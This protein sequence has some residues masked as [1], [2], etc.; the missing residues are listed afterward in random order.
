[1]KNI[2]LTFCILFAVQLAYS[3]DTI[4][5]KAFDYNSQTRDTFVTF[6]E[7]TDSYR[8]IL[9]LYNMRC[10][11]ARVSTGSNRN[12]GCGEWDYSCNTYVE[13]NSRTDSLSASTADYFISGFSGNEYNYSNSPTNT[14]YRNIQKKATLNMVTDSSSGS[15]GAGNNEVTY[16]IPISNN[17]ESGYAGKSQFIYSAE[18]LIAAGVS[19]GEIDA[20]SLNAKNVA[21]VANL[22]INILA[23]S[24]DSFQLSDLDLQGFT[25]VFSDD[26]S[27]NASN[28]L[29]T[30]HTP[31]VWDGSSNLIFEFSANSK[32]ISLLEIESHAIDSTV[33]I[34]A[35]SGHSLYFDGA[36]N[37][38]EANSFKGILGTNNRTIEAWI[39]T[40][41]VNGEI[42]SWGND[43]SG[44]KWVFRVN[45]DGTLRTEVNGG[46][47]NGTTNIADNQW[48]HVACVFAG[49]DVSDI[50]HYVDGVLETNGA[51][52][53][54]SINTTA[55][56]NVRVSRGINNRYFRGDIDGLH[57]WDEALTATRVAD[58]KNRLINP[59]DER[60]VLNYKFDVVNSD[61]VLCS[62][63]NSKPGTIMGNPTY[64]SFRAQQIFKDF[65]ISPYRP[66][67]RVHQGNFDFTISEVFDFDLV[68]NHPNSVTRYTIKSNVGTNIDDEKVIAETYNKWDA[69]KKE[70]FYDENNLLYD[71]A[72]VTSDGTITV[73]QLNYIRR[74]PSRLEIMSF[75]TPYGIG[76][77]LGAEGKTWTFDMT[78]FTPILKGEKR[79][80]LSRGG[81]NQEEMDIEFLFIKGTPAREV[82]DI[83]QIWPTQQYQPNFSQILADDVYFP[84]VAFNTLDSAKSFK[85]RSAITGHGQQGEFM[86][87]THFIKA[88]DQNFERSV[89][90]ACGKNPVYPQG[91]TWI[92]DRAGWCPG[93]ATD[94]AE[95]EISDVSGGDVITLDYGIANGEGDSRY[96]VNNQIVSYGEYNHGYDLGI[97]D[98]MEPS[99]KVEHALNNP[100]C[101]N[102]KMK[103]V[104]NGVNTVNSITVEYWV[105]DP[106][107][108][109]SFTWPCYLSTNG[110]EEIHFPIDNG[111]WSS[112]VPGDSKFYAK[113]VAID[114]NPGADEDASNNTYVSEF[115]FPEVYP[116]NFYLFYRTNNA[117][118]ETSVKIEDEWGTVVFQRDNHANATIYR[119]T[120]NLGL[121][122]Y[123][124]TID[125]SDN[126]GISFWANNDGSGF[127]RLWEVGG[128]IFK[129]IQPD[130]GS[131]SIVNFTVVHT[132]DV[133]EHEVDLG[134]HL[135]PNPST[136]LITVDGGDM[137]G[138]VPTLYNSMGQ[139][140]NAP[141][142]RTESTL[143]YDLENFPSGIY[144]LSIVKNGYTWTQKV[145]KH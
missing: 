33:G 95:Y 31:F 126:D 23:T 89:W 14:H 118:D 73:G 60:I 67:I 17:P 71:S 24:K 50:K 39:K 91:G 6:P 139:E 115:E 36:S 124:L 40:D 110:V 64:N 121:G 59:Q 145:V 116:S 113:I 85:I 120:L 92:Y 79:I 43:A 26:I 81:Q 114:G 11:G 84:P 35:F 21:Q 42:C 129:T 20:I 16:M 137:Q 101:I 108:K 132:L 144:Y 78:D 102:P 56:I 62:A 45:G 87:R 143:T 136:G 66:N 90:K 128:S 122:C 97:I 27:F 93:M 96:I 112:A 8:Q 135:Y 103:V 107:N 53:N 54:R 109:R 94:L 100:M 61:I 25:N 130:F 18:E 48:H 140:I 51:L 104:N 41:K 125:D 1:M 3:Q 57:I 22:Q 30:F 55:G 98:I 134:Y 2:A 37:Y 127:F 72:S 74:W 58:V 47:L 141:S 111:I 70:Y 133:P 12:L 82:L 32:P 28:K 52:T 5:L 15:V 13:D 65:Y 131:Q 29:I 68:P 49:T 4:R 34:V 19:A 88:N 80:F 142:Q 119:D 77:D 99:N 9:M 46:G 105:N 75:V 76:L 63:I 106:N 38:V 44:E 86:P 7:G 117:A 10:K 69:D 138:A 123:K 83:K